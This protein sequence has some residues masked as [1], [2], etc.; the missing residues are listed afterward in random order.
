VVN[1]Y[2]PAIDDSRKQFVYFHSYVLCNILLS[3]ASVGEGLAFLDVLSK[4][5]IT[6]LAN[7]NRDQ[8]PL[9]N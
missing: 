8:Y 9:H 3:G 5:Y 4:L 1:V 7:T 2:S 6:V